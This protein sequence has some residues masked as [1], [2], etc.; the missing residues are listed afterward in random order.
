MPLIS[1]FF[2]IKIYMYYDEHMPPHFHAEHNEHKILIDIN[3]NC[4]M[5]G[6]F[7]FNKLK[8]VLAWSIIHK[9]ELLDNWEKAIKK[10]EIQKIDPLK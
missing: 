5:K 10:L 2:G 3:E 1:K 4:V 9:Q 7:P 8:L 6:L